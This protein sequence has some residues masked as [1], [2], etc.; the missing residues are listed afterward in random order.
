MDS[1]KRSKSDGHSQQPKAESSSKSPKEE[2]QSSSTCELSRRL[3]ELTTESDSDEEE[4]E[5]NDPGEDDPEEN[6]PEENGLKGR[7]LRRQR[8]MRVRGRMETAR[9]VWDTERNKLATYADDRLYTE[10]ARAF[11]QE[12]KRKKLRTEMEECMSLDDT[13]VAS[14]EKKEKELE[15]LK[16]TFVKKITKRRS[17]KSILRTLKEELKAYNMVKAESQKRVMEAQMEVDK[18]QLQEAEIRYEMV[19]LWQNE[20]ERWVEELEIPILEYKSRYSP[21]ELAADDAEHLRISLQNFRTH[22][23]WCMDGPWLGQRWFYTNAARRYECDDCKDDIAYQTS[24]QAF[25]ELQDETEV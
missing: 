4:L 17:R 14:V 11:N 8:R 22:R 6:G 24:L 20:V 25:Q 16:S 10:A 5:E 13:T 1:H 23:D 3:D 19:R 18:T 9:G 2:S 15:G 7:E 12:I 21:I